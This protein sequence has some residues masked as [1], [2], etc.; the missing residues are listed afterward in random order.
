MMNNSNAKQRILVVDDDRNVCRYVAGLLTQENWLVDTA[1][2]GPTAL[3]LID[4]Q[5]YDAVVM[6]YRMPEMNGAE[7]AREIDQRQEGVP[8]VLL[9]G[10]TT[11]DIVYPAVEAG[12]DRVLS[13]PLNPQELVDVLRERLGGEEA[14][15]QGPEDIDAM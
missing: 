10:Y 12:V 13:K 6:D 14:A 8:K 15:G 7:L 5:H 3:Q 4:R 11:I 2:D 1:N 9:T